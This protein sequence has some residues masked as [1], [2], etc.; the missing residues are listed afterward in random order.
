MLTFVKDNSVFYTSSLGHYQ[1]VVVCS[2][3]QSEHD[4]KLQFF[5]FHESISKQIASEGVNERE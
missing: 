5:D 2:M 4:A 1:L 3:P